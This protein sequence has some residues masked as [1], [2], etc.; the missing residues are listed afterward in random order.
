MSTFQRDA[1]ARHAELEA[2][3]NAAL[4]VARHAI[5][6]KRGFFVEGPLHG[7]G[8]VALGA[9]LDAVAAEDVAYEG[10][11]FVQGAVRVLGVGVHDV[12]ERVF[13]PVRRR[14]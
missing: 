7:D 11:Y 12:E 10:F 14:S 5:D 13:V 9:G 6:G 2:L 8:E 4:G 1:E 3:V